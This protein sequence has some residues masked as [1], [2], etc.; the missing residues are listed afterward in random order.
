MILCHNLQASNHIGLPEL[1]KNIHLNCFYL[2]AF[3]LAIPFAW[4]SFLP[5]CHMHGFFSSLR[6]L[7]YMI[8]P[9]IVLNLPINSREI[10]LH[11]WG[12]SLLHISVFEIILFLCSL[13]IFLPTL[14]CELHQTRASDCTVY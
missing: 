11:S 7:I 4:R 6:S 12:F 9:Q 14:A 5:H 13:I 1:L 10:Y 8:S 3:A 2:R